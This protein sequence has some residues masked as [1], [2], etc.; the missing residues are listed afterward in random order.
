MEVMSL[1]WPMRP[2]GVCARANFSNSDP[3]K[4]PLWVP[5]SLDYAGTEGVDPDLFRAEL[6]GST[7]VM[8][9]TAALVPA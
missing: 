5:F 1:G 6:A 8:A 4:P 7:M 3:M 9:S 2:S